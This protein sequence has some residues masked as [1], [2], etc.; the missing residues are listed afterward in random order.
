MEV[1]ACSFDTKSDMYS[2]GTSAIVTLN[3]IG[4]AISIVMALASIVVGVF[5]EITPLLVRE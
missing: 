4:I 2:P 5:Q 3:A 1:T